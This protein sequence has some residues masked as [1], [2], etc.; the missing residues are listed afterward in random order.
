MN[1]SGRFAPLRANTL[2]LIA[3]LAATLVVG[4]MATDMF[5]SSL[6]T[7]VFVFDATTSRVQL[8]LSVYL[9][10]FAIAQ[11]VYGPVSDRFGRR[12]PLLAGTGLFVVA[13][14]G[15]ALSTSIEMLIVFRFV[16]S[17]G[18]AAGYVI[19]LAIVRDMHDRDIA[20]SMLARLGTVIG[21]SPA[22]APVIGGYL[23]VWFGWQANF[24]FLAAWAVFVMVLF[25][26]LIQES[27]RHPDPHALRP[28]KIVRNYGLLLRNRTYLGYSLTLVFAFSTFFAFLSGAPFVF[29]EVLGVAPQNFAWLI[30]IQVVGFVAGTT[31]ADRLTK[32]IGIDRLL[33]MAV[34]LAAFGGITTGL[35]PWLG[36]ASVFGIIAPMVVFAFAI[37]IIFPLGTAGAIG[38]FP[39][40]AGSAAALLGFLE[41]AAGAAFGAL[42]G[43]LHDG[44]VIPMTSVM[45]LTASL[46][47]AVFLLLLW[48][49]PTEN[50]DAE[51]AESR[52]DV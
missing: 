12:I 16:Q 9:F 45:G 10:G 32:R 35:L 3:V 43:V 20:A 19:A 37:G 5:L 25:A 21:I 52:S 30:T 38:P 18:G 48:R 11:L 40:M 41:S 23:L 46:S 24:V 29:I 6:P 26:L 49:R 28:V 36:I 39:H 44:S 50:V 42:V 22:I 31:L 8:T 17:L 7:L 33:E 14:M 4:E 1:L 47:L 34:L 27:N 2:S 13:T 15:A 51:M